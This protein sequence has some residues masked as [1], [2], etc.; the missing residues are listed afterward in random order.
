[1]TLQYSYTGWIKDLKVVNDITLTKVVSN[2]KQSTET[3]ATALDQLVNHM[4]PKKLAIN[5]DPYLAMLAWTYNA[6]KHPF[7]NNIMLM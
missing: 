2:M 3:L 1:M 4:T 6:Q 5:M 7:N